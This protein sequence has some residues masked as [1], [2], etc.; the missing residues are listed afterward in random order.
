[1]PTP[2]V[3]LREQLEVI[4]NTVIR[5]EFPT[6]V[7]G[8]GTLVPITNEVDYR[9]ETFSYKLFSSVGEAKI[10]AN[11]ASD[12]PMVSAY[13]QKKMGIIRTLVDGYEITLEDLEAAQFAN[14]N[15]S[16]EMAIAART[17]IEE[18]ID[19]IGYFGAAENELLGL[20]NLPNVVRETAPN[21]GN[22]NGG[23]NSTRW[24]HKD[25]SQLYAELTSFLTRTR[26][27]T[28]SIEKPE[29]LLIPQAQYDRISELVFPAN[30]DNTLLNFFMQ[31]Q[32]AN[33]SGIKEI[34]PVEML[35]GAGTGGSD[36]MIAYQRNPAKLR[37]EIPLDFEQRPPQVINFTTKVVCRARVGGLVNLK[38]MSVRYYE[39]I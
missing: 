22:L 1:M 23:T 16:A 14:M 31:T 3:F 7:M 11:G 17:A 25:A 24:Q 36:L 6:L 38:P 19:R 28:K 21:N 9:A 30:T 37:Y 4:T 26:Q 34:I 12:I 18:G 10:L 29:I 33:A 2:S 8:N 27:A 39:G 5:Q 15:L 32:R 35:S 13:V 20:V